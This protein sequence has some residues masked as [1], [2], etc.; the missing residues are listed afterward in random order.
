MTLSLKSYIIGFL[1]VVTA[2][3]LYE[4]WYENQKND[5]LE[6]DLSI[7]QRQLVGTEAQLKAEINAQKTIRAYQTQMSTKQTQQIQRVSGSDAQQPVGDT[8]QSAVE[9]IRGVDDVPKVP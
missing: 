5:Q 4:A 9:A 6:E 8:I 2:F 7:V 1:I 3:S